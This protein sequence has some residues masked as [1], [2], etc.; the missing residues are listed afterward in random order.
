[1]KF[2]E[3]YQITVSPEEDPL[4][5]NPKEGANQK[6]ISPNL[7]NNI[8]DCEE[9]DAFGVS[10][11]L[12]FQAFPE[13]KEPSLK[14]VFPWSVTLDPLDRLVCHLQNFISLKINRL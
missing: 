5:D 12:V 3:E 8:P 10:V 6:E 11:S 9:K 2:C 1:M 4:R 14:N 13:Q 7:T